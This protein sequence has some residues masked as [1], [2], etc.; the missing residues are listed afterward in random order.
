[1]CLNTGT[2]L[3]AKLL[4]VCIHACA[5]VCMSA[6]VAKVHVSFAARCTCSVVVLALLG[7]TKAG[8]INQIH[9]RDWTNVEG[10][11]K[12][13]GTETMTAKRERE[14]ETGKEND[15]QRRGT[16]KRPERK[17]DTEKEKN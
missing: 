1:M 12:A 14:D 10:Q 11:M 8:P 5:C 15:R 3:F 7:C 17:K 4:A 9:F 16:V 2:F 6:C 13:E